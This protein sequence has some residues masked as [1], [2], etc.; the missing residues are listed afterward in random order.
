MSPASSTD[1]SKPNP[2]F[3]QH[4]SVRENDHLSK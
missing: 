3:D 2:R 4:R 1:S